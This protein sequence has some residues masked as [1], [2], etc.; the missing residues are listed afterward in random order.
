MLRIELHVA[1]FMESGMIYFDKNVFLNHNWF[2]KIKTIIKLR[3]LIRE[4]TME[5]I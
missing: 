5:S 4:K 2:V 3:Q 1:C